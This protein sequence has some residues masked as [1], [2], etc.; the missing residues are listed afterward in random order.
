MTDPARV[1]PPWWQRHLLDVLAAFGALAV[2]G[3]A[4]H[5]H[6]HGSERGIDAL[7]IALGLVGMAAVVARRVSP[8]ASLVVPCAA[9]GAYLLLHYPNGP[10]Y[11]LLPLGVFCFGFYARRGPARRLGPV[12]VLV[13][14]AC[15]YVAGGQDTILRV[16]IV[17]SWGI[18]ALILAEWLRTIAD[19]AIERRK[20]LQ[21]QQIRAQV[22]QQLEL[23]RDLHDSVAHAL[24]AITVQAALAERL[25]KDHPEQAIE[26]ARAA[27][28]AGRDALADLGAIVGSLREPGAAPTRPQHGLD[29][30]DGLVAGAREAGLRVEVDSGAL[31]GI[32]ADVQAAAY[33]VVQEG[34]TNAVRYAPGGRLALSM[35]AE[36]SAFRVELVDDGP[37]EGSIA[38]PS[39][40][41]HGLVGMA[42][43]VR[44]TG[45]VLRHGPRPDGGYFVEAR[46][47]TP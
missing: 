34:L 16:S 3:S 29:E 15:A 47:E 18:A 9:V 44:A 4:S 23:A 36:R 42:E 7:A 21:Q 25:A 30:I 22:E 31:D 28:I 37:A 43:R 13:V 19:R 10:A 5:L 40:G 46:W 12:A 20:A 35:T 33:R 32:A 27:R 1:I 26:A 45:G 41:G 8:L 2:I 17:L 24:T 14:A 38:Q 39:G 11:F 6:V